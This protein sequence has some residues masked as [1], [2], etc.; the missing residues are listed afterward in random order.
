MMIRLSKCAL[1]AAIAF[2]YSLVV[3]NNLTDYESNRQFVRH[4]LSMDNTFPGN[5]GM[6]RAIPS[7]RIQTLFYIVIIAWELCTAVLC[8]WATVRLLRKLHASAA[9]FDEAKP[10]AIAALTFGC[11]MWFVAFLSIGAEW[12]LMWQS[13]TWNGQ[14]AA[15]RMFTMIAI[16]LVYIAM[17]D[18]QP[19]TANL[20]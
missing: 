17:P 4:V 11:L 3:F 14:E 20:D 13:Q 8:W 7:A 16:V 18:Q 9:G 6:W 15:F 1:L 2:F 12:F 5:H 19:R 10:M